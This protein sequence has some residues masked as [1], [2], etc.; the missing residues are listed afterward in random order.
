MPG[1]HD[2]AAE[3]V[4]EALLSEGVY[5][6]ALR[7]GH[8]LVGRVPRRRQEIIACLAAGRSVKL[9]LSPFDLSRGWIEDLN[10]QEP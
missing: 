9:K 1:A 8:R 2:I 10:R 7:N 4:I 5:R 6:V 3:G